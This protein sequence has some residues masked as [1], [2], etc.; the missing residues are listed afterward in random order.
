MAGC[1]NLGI[2]QPEVP[3]HLQEVDMPV[4]MERQRPV[5][6]TVLDCLVAQARG[7]AMAVAFAAAAAAAEV[8]EESVVVRQQQDTCF[9]VQQASV[10]RVGVDGH[11]VCRSHRSAYDSLH[12]PNPVAP[13]LR[14]HAMAKKVVA[15]GRKVLVWQVG[16]RM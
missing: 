7:Q 14:V 9:L 6:G 12:R 1:H 13:D 4:A 5:A 3:L 11:P 10:Q 16:G 15:V 2:V 8:R